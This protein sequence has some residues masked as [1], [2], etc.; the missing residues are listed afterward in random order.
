MLDRWRLPPDNFPDDTESYAFQNYRHEG[1][2]LIYLLSTLL[3]YWRLILAGGVLALGIGV[4]AAAISWLGAEPTV[5]VIPRTD[6]TPTPIGDLLLQLNGDFPPII[7][8]R[9]VISVPARIQ[10]DL[11]FGTGRG[12]VFWGR[13]GVAWR[14]TVESDG[15]FDPIVTLYGPPNGVFLISNDDRSP[16]EI[17]SEIISTFATDGLYAIAVQSADGASGGAYTMTML[18]YP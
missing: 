4:V 15:S 9:Q 11:P 10:D 1:N 8:E 5:V 13:A 3:P 14:I 12:Y 6:I 18:P 16:G 17:S 2:R 7:T